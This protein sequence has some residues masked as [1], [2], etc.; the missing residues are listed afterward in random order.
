M[1]FLQLLISNLLTQPGFFIGLLVFVGLLVIKKPVYEAVAGFVKT[2]VGFFILTVGSSGLTSTFSPIISAL[3]TRFGMEAAMVDTYFLMG[4]MYG[5]DGLYSIGNALTWTMITFGISFAWNFILV[6][7]NKWTR[8]RTLYVTGHTMQVYSTIFIWMVYLVSPESRNLSFSILFGIL[9]GT[10]SA[11]G[12]NLTVEATQ[13]LT[14]NGGF[15]VGHQVM[16]GIWFTDKA[17]HLFGKKEDSV[18]NIKLPGFFV[19]FPR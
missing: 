15:A 5:E 11:V 10:W 17:A 8:C 19:C 7:F 4:Q 13:N 12:S 18:E 9:D 2:S 3:K 14:G 6:I 1:E 16:L